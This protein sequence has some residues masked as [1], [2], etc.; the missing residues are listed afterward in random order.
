[1]A[2]CLAKLHSRLQLHR[3]Q[4]LRL[5]TDVIVKMAASKWNVGSLG[6]GRFQVF[7]GGNLSLNNEE[8]ELCVC[9]MF[10]N[11][12]VADNFREKFLWYCVYISHHYHNMVCD[13]SHAIQDVHETQG[14]KTETETLDPET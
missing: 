14:S 10:L 1:M 9:S 7:F 2:S 6:T 4:F 3:L 11:Y 13:Y 8:V 12:N 5:S